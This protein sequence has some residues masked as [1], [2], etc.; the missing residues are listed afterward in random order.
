[1]TIKNFL[2]FCVIFLSTT[3]TLNSQATEILFGYVGSLYHA[4]GENIAAKLAG[5]SG[6]NVTQVNLYNQTLT[7]L[8]GYDQV[9][10]YDLSAE[11]DNNAHQ[12]ANY[13]TVANWY[14]NRTT[15]TKNLI[16]DGRIISSADF[17]INLPSN[18]GLPSETGWIQNYALQLDAR[19]GG[20]VLG[21][22]H[23]VFNFGINTINSLIGIDDFTGI[24]YSQ[25]LQAYVDDESPL[26]LNTLGNCQIDPAKKC[27]NDNSSTSFVPTGLQANG[28]FLAPVA[29]HG[30]F[31]EAFEFAAVSSTLGSLTFPDPTQVPEPGALLLMLLGLF[32]I[33][34]ARKK[35]K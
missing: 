7:D 1:M 29:W 8:S 16:A 34:L 26:Y 11:A 17:W 32:G 9:W 6:A 23:N 19:G 10:I 20:L 22:D 28:Q 35:V 21:T 30:S 25:P 15:A 14:N 5:I 31:S 13:S 18:D 4:D 24:Y 33:H 3:F 27:I 2:R 12:T